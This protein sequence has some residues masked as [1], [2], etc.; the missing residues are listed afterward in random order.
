MKERKATRAVT[1]KGQVTI[2][3]EIRR[4]LEIEPYDR[5]VFYVEDDKVYLA[6]EGETIESNFGAV[7]PL[8]QP[9][10]FQALRD[11]AIEG[12]VDQTIKEMTA[13]NEIS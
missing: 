5:V 11:R 7:T 3:V 8:S 13:N 2:P 12:R 9:E 4:M 1:Q 6:P 10:D